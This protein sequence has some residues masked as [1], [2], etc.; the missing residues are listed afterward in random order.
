MLNILQVSLQ[1]YA[2]SELPYVQPGFRKG[3]GTRDQLFNIHWISNL[4][5]HQQMNGWE[6]CGTYTP[7]NIT[8]PLKRIHLNQF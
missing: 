8:Q 7:W 1:H 2:N 6:S 5:A 4:D 3:R